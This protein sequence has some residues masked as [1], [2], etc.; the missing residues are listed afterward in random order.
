MQYV[1]CLT[2]R[3]LYD[4]VDVARY[5]QWYFAI[6]TSLTRNIRNITLTVT[7]IQVEEETRS[8]LNKIAIIVLN[9]NHYYLFWNKFGIPAHHNVLPLCYNGMK[10]MLRDGARGFR[11]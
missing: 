8:R 1:Q 2:L 4:S 9:Q 7:M 5:E 11:T 6:A 10:R 3:K